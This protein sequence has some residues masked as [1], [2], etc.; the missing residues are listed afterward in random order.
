MKTFVD[1]LAVRKVAELMHLPEN[2][3]RTIVEC[4]MSGL[5]LRKT[6]RKVKEKH[7]HEIGKDSVKKVLLK[8]QELAR[9]TELPPDK[10]LER[11][12]L[13]LEEEKREKRLREEAERREEE[14]CELRKE[15]LLLRLENEGDKLIKKVVKRRVWR[16]NPEL[17]KRFKEF[18]KQHEFT[19][20]C[21]IQYLC[22]AESIS[23]YIREF[24]E[25][26][27]SEMEEL[28]GWIERCMQ[29]TLRLGIS[30]KTKLFMEMYGP[31]VCPSCEDKDIILRHR[32]EEGDVVG[33]FVSHHISFW[34][35]CP[36]CQVPM[37]A[38]E[39]E[40]VVRHQYWALT[41]EKKKLEIIAFECPRCKLRWKKSGSQEWPP[42]FV[43]SKRP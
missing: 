26:E 3:V 5:G 29:D 11:L 24:Y 40:S 42:H 39:G 12:T 33:C 38:V 37:K 6:S 4:Q 36:S 8:Y 22:D 18:C 20:E 35:K 10:E 34:V 31:F 9:P 25:G 30:L 7:G 23:H 14:K 43:Y 32:S 28:V 17:H 15:L 16:K 21:A 1:E 13:K 41:G 19:T 27:W 2:V